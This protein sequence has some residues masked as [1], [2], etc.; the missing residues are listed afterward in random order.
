MFRT[1][2]ATTTASP[3]PKPVHVAREALRMIGEHLR[4][5]YDGITLPA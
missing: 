1:D 4:N 3:I 5:A 2:P